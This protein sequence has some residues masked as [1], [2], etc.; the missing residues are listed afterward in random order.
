MAT[1]LVALDLRSLLQVPVAYGGAEISSISSINNGQSTG[2]QAPSLSPFLGQTRQ[3]VPHGIWRRGAQPALVPTALLRRHGRRSSATVAAAASAD[4]AAGEAADEVTIDNCTVLVVGG[5]GVGMEVV[6]GLATAG[7]WVTA[8]QRADKFRQ[9]IEGLGAM[10]ANGDVLERSTLERALRSNT[11]DAV[12]CTVGGGLTNINVDSD[13][14]INVIEAAKKAGVPRFVLVSS[15][16]VGNSESAVEEQTLKTLGPVLKEK[17]KAEAALTNSGLHW[18]I[19]RPGG[20]LSTPKSGT[21]V[22]TEDPAVVGTISRTDVADLISKILFN[23]SAY[24]KVL[25]AIDSARTFPGMEDK[26]YE[27]FQL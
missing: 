7:S 15:I 11:F 20:L 23:K 9:E 12:I 8:F 1:S 6:R 24:G 2:A 13:G 16:G 21:G 14:A 25:A 19:V 5:G 10:L 4:V 18:T 26:K 22:L 3:Q 17:A 27:V